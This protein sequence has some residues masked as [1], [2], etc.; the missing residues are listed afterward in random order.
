MPPPPPVEEITT[1][2][3][4][5]EH[6]VFPLVETRRDDLGNGSSALR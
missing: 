6:A 1:R 5:L 2:L 3:A 4:R